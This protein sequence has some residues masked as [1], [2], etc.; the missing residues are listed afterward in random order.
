MAQNVYNLTG[1]ITFSSLSFLKKIQK[2]RYVLKYILQLNSFLTNFQ[3]LKM[4]QNDKIVILPVTFY[5][6]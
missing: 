5:A 1:K 6:L 3:V 2:M 4:P